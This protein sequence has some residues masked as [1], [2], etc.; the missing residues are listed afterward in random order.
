MQGER[1]AWAAAEEL[2]LDV[3]AILPAWV[4]GPIVTK[5]VAGSSSVCHFKVGWHNICLRASLDVYIGVGIKPIPGPHKK[6]CWKG[7]A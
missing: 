3:V 4:I 2:G 5:D 6:I 1:A 7:I